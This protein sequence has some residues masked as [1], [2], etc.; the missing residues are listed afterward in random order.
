MHARAAGKCDLRDA[1]WVRALPAYDAEI[2]LMFAFPLVVCVVCWWK[3]REMM[4]V[5]KIEH[6][7]L[8]RDRIPEIIERTG[9]KCEC[10]IL[11]DEDY[12]ICLDEKLAEELAEYQADKSLE[13]LADLLEVL[14]AVAEARASF[15]EVD[16][17]R[18]AKKAARG[19]F[20]KRIFLKSTLNQG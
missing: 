19:G 14:M 11:S 18:R 13:E 4:V 10:E 6:N 12:M 20:E 7:K 15:A 9:S 1:G 5:A 16:A 3:Q 17:I 8:V 2:N